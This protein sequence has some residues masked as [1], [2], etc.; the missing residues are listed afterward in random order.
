ME[1]VQKRIEQLRTMLRKYSYEY[2]VN[3]APSVPDSEYD[4]LM[5]ELRSLEQKYPQFHDPNSPTEIVNGTVS[6]KFEKIVHKR[7]MLSLGNAY[8]FE[9]LKAFDEAVRKEA[10]NVRYEVELKIDGLAM[11]ITYIN[12]KFYQA[13]TRGD[14]EVGEDVTANVRT[15]PTI[16][17]TISL[18]DEIEIRGEV[19]MPKSSFE[20]LNAKRLENGEELFANP[21]NAAAGSVRQLDYRIAASR[22]LDGFWYH[23]CDAEKWVD[24]HSGSLQMLDELGF[25]TNPVR[26]VCDTMEE[27]WEHIQDMTGKRSSLPYEIDGMVIKVDSLQAQRQLGTTIRVPKWAIAYKFPAEEV[28]TKLEDIFVTVGR[29]G[30]ITPNARLTPVRIAGTSVGFAQLHNLDNITAK[31]I[32]IGDDVVVRKAGDII[33]EVLRSLPERR[34]GSQIPYEFPKVCPVCGSP[35][36][37]FEDEAHHYCLNTEC[38]ARITESIAHF[39]SRD[40]MNIEGLGIKRVEQLHQAGLLNHIDDIYNLK[41]EEEKILALDKMGKNSFLN[42]VS[43]IENSKQ[44]PLDKLLTGLGIKQVGEKAA[45]V[46]AQKFVTMEALQNATVEELTKVND[47]GEITAIGLRAYFDDEHNKA[48]LTALKAHGVRMDCDVAQQQES[49]FTGKTVVL[50]GT[51]SKYDRKEATEKLEQL[52]AKVTSSVTKKTDLVIYGESAGSKLTKAQQLQIETMDEEAFNEM[53]QEYE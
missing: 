44:N 4:T 15:I 10:G 17:M 26:K 27:V 14:G 36:H 30:K 8:N 33:P 24:T 51:L 13:V 7:M 21:R 2:Y 42:L 49:Y 11:S 45:K 50:T 28:V 48:I 23:V 37:K 25:V 31:D 12:G 19:Y 34:D 40:A 47:I 53:M 18:K 43:A 41:F 9:D 32:R 5:N 16:P 22:K 52:G 46:L 20:E 38:E 39:A 1:E 6:E 29:T 3:D 35:L